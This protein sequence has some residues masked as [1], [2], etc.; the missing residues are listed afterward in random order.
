VS[1]SPVTS[2]TVAGRLNVFGGVGGL[3]GAATAGTLACAAAP[4]AA[5]T[6]VPAS[7]ERVLVRTMLSPRVL[8]R[9]LA[10]RREV[11][12]KDTRGSRDRLRERGVERLL[13]PRAPAGAG[14]VPR[15]GEHPAAGELQDETGRCHEPKRLTVE[16]SYGE[17]K[18]WQRVPVTADQVAR[19]NHPAG[20]T[21]VSLRA[22]AAARDGNTVKQT[23]IRVYTLR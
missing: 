10:S 6:S 15:R 5:A 23:V 2:V 16:M 8:R 4:T 17:G 14:Q 3:A 11:S 18:T 1:T 13:E 9:H 19:L 7:H 21:S 22:S 12:L 20:A